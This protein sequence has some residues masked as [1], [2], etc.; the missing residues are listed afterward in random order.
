MWEPKVLGEYEIGQAISAIKEI[1]LRGK[2]IA[3]VSSTRAKKADL[4]HDL[5]NCIQLAHGKGKVFLWIENTGVEKWKGLQ[6]YR[7]GFY[8]HSCMLL[9]LKHMIPSKIDPLVRHVFLGLLFGYRPD[10]I[11]KFVVKQKRT[12]KKSQ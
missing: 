6:R 4:V 2:P 3:E 9:A 10:A 5:K 1:L 7:Y 12:R 8:S 11:Q